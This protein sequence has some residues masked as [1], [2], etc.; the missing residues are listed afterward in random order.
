MTLSIET[1]EI[2]SNFRVHEC[3]T[4]IILLGLIHPINDIRIIY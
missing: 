2:E 4:H 1:Y 3:I